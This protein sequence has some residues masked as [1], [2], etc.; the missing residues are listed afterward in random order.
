MLHNKL[1]LVLLICCITL[2]SSCT[3]RAQKSKPV[4]FSYYTAVDA[5]EFQSVGII[6]FYYAPDIGPS[7][8]IIDKTMTAAIRELGSFET[9]IIQSSLR[10][11]VLGADIQTLSAIDPFTLRE[12]RQVTHVDAI[13]IGRVAQYD[14]YDPISI[15]VECHMVSCTD[16]RTLWSA[17]AHFDSQRTD[18]QEDISNWYKRS[19]GKGNENIGSWELTLHTPKLFCRYVSDRLAASVL[20]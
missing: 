4:K 11:Q 1:C 15:G 5:T 14:G 16:G 8:R 13:I 19:V 6:P 17:S 12:I 2:L 10:D 20:F 3:L 7:A 9:S 18:I